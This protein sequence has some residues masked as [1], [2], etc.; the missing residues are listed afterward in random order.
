MYDRA[1][2]NR[3]FYTLFIAQSLFS[4]AQI[5]IFTLIAIVAAVALY[6]LSDDKVGHS[7]LIPYFKDLALPLIRSG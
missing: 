5:A 2:S 7:L 6:H 4:A 3:L 1:T